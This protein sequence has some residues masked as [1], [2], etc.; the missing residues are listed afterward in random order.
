MISNMFLI[1]SILL[2]VLLVI[3]LVRP[4]LGSLLFDRAEQSFLRL[5]RR[6]A[7]SVTLVGL[8]ALVLRLALLPILPIPEPIVHDEFGYLLIGDT[9]AQGRVTNP[10]HPMWMHFET[11][12]VIQRP[13]YQCYTPPAQGAA[14]AMG[15]VIAGHPFW[16]VWFSMG[17][18]CAALCWMLQ[19]WLPPGWALL[20]GVLAIL[21][22]G[23]FGYWA[24]SYWGGAL[25]AI[26]GALVLGSLPRMMSLQRAR[27]AITMGAG[28]TI[29]ANSRPYEG[30]VF[31]I[32]VAIGLLIWVFNA[33]GPALAVKFRRVVFPLCLTLAVGCALTGYYFWR[34][35]GSPLRSP[36]Q[37]ERETYS[38]LP[39]L[40]W[41]PLRPPPSYNH[42]V[43]EAAYAD[44]VEGFKFNRSWPG[45]VTIPITRMARMWRFYLGP[46]LTFPFL[47]LFVVLPYGFGWRSISSQTQFLLSV[48][49]T[50]GI[51]V[52]GL[53][54]TLF[55]PHYAAPLAC[56]MLALLL[57]AMRELRVWQPRG[58]PVGLF[59]VRATLAVCVVMFVIRCL[60]GPMHI[61]L[62]Q[63][64]VPA[65]DQRGP[66]SF[67]RAAVARNLQQLP[68][69]H[70]VI[71]RYKPD[72]NA[73]A[74]WV[75]NEPDID[76]AKVVWARAMTPQKDEELIRYFPGRKVWFLDADE[77]PAKLEP[78]D[79]TASKDDEKER[80]SPQLLL[81]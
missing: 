69:D 48:A 28:L 72:H 73:F 11:F 47:M 76:A 15:K 55:S 57:S 39:Y 40:I 56:V 10:T 6:P 34:V 23:V 27:H 2:T 38:S 54:A 18:M 44:E 21:R 30:L 61:A 77:K 35:T 51:G 75:Y 33:R 66:N 81:Q 62:S 80:A 42:Q 20:G 24:N 71:V 14:L 31:S 22:W 74:E 26:G 29:L 8:S 49:I 63:S 1:E 45:L 46:A 4:G 32:P 68:G 37:V 13:T 50:F 41:Q 17:L 7:L 9:F 16:G 3:A 78:Y 65:W 25:G 52:F 70:L 19:G 58:R 36:Y 64:H 53:E 59:M 60:A 79:V 43:I 12:S 67:G 5:A